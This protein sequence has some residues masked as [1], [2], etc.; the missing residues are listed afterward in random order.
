MHT[1]MSFNDESQKF[2]CL[3]Y[4]FDWKRMKNNR[5]IKNLQLP[6]GQNTSMWNTYNV[7]EIWNDLIWS[8]FLGNLSFKGSNFSM[9][10]R[11]IEGMLESLKRVWLIY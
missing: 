3:L 1:Y 6:I 9:E 4:A 11:L 8:P 2:L 10:M 5:N 7:I